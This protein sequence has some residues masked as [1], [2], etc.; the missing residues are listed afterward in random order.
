MTVKIPRSRT[1][2]GVK[3]Q[4]KWNWTPEY[5]RDFTKTWRATIKPQIIDN[6]VTN[7]NCRDSVISRRAEMY[8][9]WQKTRCPSLCA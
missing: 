4:P 6:G 1:I 9:I 8:R 3:V 2:A 5:A 7:T